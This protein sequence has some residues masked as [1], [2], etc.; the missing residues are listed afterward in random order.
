MDTQP[1]VTVPS[2]T[3]RLYYS[4][5]AILLA[6]G[7]LCHLLSAQAIGGHYVAYRDHILGFVMLT[8]VSIAIVGG[9]GW[10]FWKGRHD[11]TLLIVGALQLILGIVVW[12]NRF[13]VA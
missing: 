6:A 8:V 4:L 5:G 1:P 10:R 3:N 13:H 9:L 7:L 12:I 2:P 11:I